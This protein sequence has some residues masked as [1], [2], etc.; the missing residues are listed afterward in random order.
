MEMQKSVAVLGE[1]IDRM[2]IDIGSMSGKLDAANDK[3]D[4]L[5]HWQTTVTAGAIVVAAL[6]GIIWS[7]IT[8]V[9][10]DR[11]QIVPEPVTTQPAANTPPTSAIPAKP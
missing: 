10:W 4:R 9:P 6:A 11:I 5:K 8:F 2:G 1:K 7:I 3:M